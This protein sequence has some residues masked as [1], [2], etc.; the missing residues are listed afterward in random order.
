MIPVS[1]YS[2][3]YHLV[4]LHFTQCSNCFL[5]LGIKINTKFKFVIITVKICRYFENL[6]K[7]STIGRIASPR[8]GNEGIT[9]MCDHR[10]GNLLMN[11]SPW[12]RETIPLNFRLSAYPSY[13]LS[14]SGGILSPW[15]NANDEQICRTA[16]FF[17]VPCCKTKDSNLEI[18][19]TTLLFCL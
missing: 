11:S 10:Q 14:F 5:W 18:P 19:F 16:R 13:L 17:R 1:L 6:S 12:E 4:L 8:W 7:S 9:I 3:W 15:C 2:F